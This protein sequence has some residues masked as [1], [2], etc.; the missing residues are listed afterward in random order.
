[1]SE[2]FPPNIATLL[3]SMLLVRRKELITALVVAAALLLP[4][5]AVAI[6]PDGHFNHVT[7]ITSEE[8]FVTHIQSE[9]NAD[10]TLF[11]RWIASP[12]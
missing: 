2:V 1:L 12:S 6:Y 3:Y 8:Y 9:I 10:K 11:V 7:E 5:G 4:L